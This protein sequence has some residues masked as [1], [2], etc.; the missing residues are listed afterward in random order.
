MKQTHSKNYL[1]FLIFSIAYLVGFSLYYLTTGNA[2]FIWYVIILLIVGTIVLKTRK[3]SKMDMFALWG[4]S[5]WGFIHMLA[6]SL[7]VDSVGTVLYGWNI[8][9]LLDL[10]SVFSPEFY[11]LKFDQLVHFYGFGVA[12]IVMY[13]LIARRSITKIHPGMLIFFATV[14]SMGLGAFNEVVEFLAMVA[15]ENNGV[16]DIYNLGLDLIFNTAGALAGAFLAQKRE[17]KT[18]K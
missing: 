3:V 2:E 15:I 18:K 8:F 4:L 10:T 9:T 11:I 5:I 7:V 12:A 13:Q 6:G 1:A 14:A 16:G 17:S